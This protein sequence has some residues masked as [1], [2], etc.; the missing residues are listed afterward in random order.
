MG[1]QASHASLAA[2]FPASIVSG[3]GC[4]A[5]EVDFVKQHVT[6]AET[7]IE[8]IQFVEPIGNKLDGDRQ[9]TV[10]HL[11]LKAAQ[12]GDL[13]SLATQLARGALP[14]TRQPY[15]VRPQKMKI[16]GD[17]GKG[18]TALMYCAQAGH[19]EAVKLLLDAQANVSSEDEDGL[20]AL[21]FAAQA[22]AYDVGRLLVERGADPLAQDDFGSSA[23][24]MLPREVTRCKSACR[25]WYE[26][27]GADVDMASRGDD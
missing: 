2:S 10:D 4:Q 21:H 17:R 13:S 20:Q 24:E 6:C 1:A 15:F 16:L 14:D 23:I 9:A 22:G 5:S 7:T 12:E 25:Q 19:L 8:I 3:C 27:L 11:L 26:L 18:L